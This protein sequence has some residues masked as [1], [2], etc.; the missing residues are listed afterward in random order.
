MNRI[1]NICTLEKDANNYMKNRTVCKSCYNEN[2]RKNNDFTLIQNQ[3]PKIDMINSNNDNNSNVS[4]FENQ[5][6]VVIDTGNVGKP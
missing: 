1:C 4:T 2:R 6:Y 3:Q 5:A